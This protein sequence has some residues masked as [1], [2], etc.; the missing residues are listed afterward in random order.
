[1][2][3]TQNLHLNTQFY[4]YDHWITINICEFGVETRLKH[5]PTKFSTKHRLEINN[6]KDRGGVKYCHGEG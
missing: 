4:G 6:G 2:M 5:V 1:M 3:E